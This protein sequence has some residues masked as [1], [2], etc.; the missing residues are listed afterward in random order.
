MDKLNTVAEILNSKHLNAI[1]E[2]ERNIIWKDS[3]GLKNSINVDNIDIADG[4]TAWFQLNVN[5]GDELFIIFENNTFF[6]FPPKTMHPRYG[7]DIY[8]LECYKDYLIL[9]YHKK[10]NVVIT[11]VKDKEIITFE[12]Y[13]DELIRRGELLYFKDYGLKDSVRRLKIPEIKELESITMKE[14]IENNTIPETLG[15]LNDLRQ[16][17]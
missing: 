8:L 16:L 12:F 4:K 10:H 3:S 6:E 7:C 11:S 17:F 9:I 14:A 1:I 2:D 15:Y 5:N 13:G